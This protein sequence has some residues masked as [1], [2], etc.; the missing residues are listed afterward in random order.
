M[1]QRALMKSSAERCISRLKQPVALCSWCRRF[2]FM[3]P[4]QLPRG[5]P[6]ARVPCTSS[7]LHMQP[8]VS[9][10]QSTAARNGCAFTAALPPAPQPSRSPASFNSS[11][12]TRSCTGHGI[13]PIACLCHV[14]GLSEAKI[15]RHLQG[16]PTAIASE[17]LLDEIPKSHLHAQSFAAG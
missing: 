11:A 8:A 5:R 2:I 15:A 10:S 6:S 3:V 16:A 7:L 14:G 1:C 9:A 4:S 17:Q 12:R 13:S